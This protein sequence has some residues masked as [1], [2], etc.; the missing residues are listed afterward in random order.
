[1]TRKEQEFEERICKL[2]VARVA[3]EIQAKEA[4]RRLMK[5]SKWSNARGFVRSLGQRREINLG[6]TWDE[7]HRL[8]RL[9]RN[10]YRLRGLRG[11]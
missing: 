11:F 7:S 3:L 6:A 10:P 2:D 9:Y 1:M 8:V 5:T 4:P